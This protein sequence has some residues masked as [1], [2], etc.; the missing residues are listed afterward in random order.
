M[1]FG[2]TPLGGPV[3]TRYGPMA[4]LTSCGIILFSVALML[5]RWR[6]RPR[7]ST[8]IQVVATLGVLLS[9]IALTSHFFTAVAPGLVHA[10]THTAFPAAI[11]LLALLFGL[12]VL[13]PDGSWLRPFQD[14]GEAGVLA[15][16]LVPAVIAGPL[17]VNWM[18]LRGAAA[19]RLHRRTSAP[20]SA[21]C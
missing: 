8:A 4:P 13:T 3:P 20:S 12:L 14:S 7:V 6:H 15:R 21:R 2:N 19:R 16:R 17:L 1:L 10:Y 9:A 5:L 18:T 11:A